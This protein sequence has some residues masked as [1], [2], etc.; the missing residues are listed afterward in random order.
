V[1]TT[2]STKYVSIASDILARINRLLVR[3]ARAREE[4][5]LTLPELFDRAEAVR[6]ENLLWVED[7]EE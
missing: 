6:Y 1:T 5:T 3:N 7:K 2:T 4:T